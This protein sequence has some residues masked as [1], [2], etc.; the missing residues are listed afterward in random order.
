MTARSQY[1]VVCKTEGKHRTS[2]IENQTPKWARIHAAIRCS[3]VGC[4]MLDVPPGSWAGRILRWLSA[5]PS[6]VSARRTSRTTEPAAGCSISMNR[7]SERGQP[8]P[9]ES[10]PRNLRTR[11]SA[12]LSADGAYLDTATNVSTRRWSAGLRPGCYSSKVQCA[13][14]SFGKFSPRGRA[15]NSNSASCPP[16]ARGIFP[17]RP[18]RPA[19][20][21]FARAKSPRDSE[22]TA[23]IPG[24]RWSA[25]ERSRHPPFYQRASAHHKARKQP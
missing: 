2:N 17:R 7:L 21:L 3:G 19:S 6:A 24:A 4:S 5:Q 1:G 16:T 10:S 12:L 23:G 15:P 9:P 11:L 14:F 8:C 22:G 20:P 13:K 18:R 25:R